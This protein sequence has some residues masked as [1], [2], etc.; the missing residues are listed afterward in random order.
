MVEWKLGAV[1]AAYLTN[2]RDDQIGKRWHGNG[3]RLTPAVENLQVRDHLTER[4]YALA[5]IRRFRR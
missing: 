3:T 2:P 1:T 4:Q 5:V